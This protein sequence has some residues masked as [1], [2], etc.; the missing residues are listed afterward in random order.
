MPPLLGMHDGGEGV[1]PERRRAA[2]AAAPGIANF[3]SEDRARRLRG[4]LCL[5]RY[6]TVN[7]L[8]GVPADCSL[9]RYYVSPNIISRTLA[10]SALRR[11]YLA[12]RP[13]YKLSVY[14]VQ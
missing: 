11:I 2:A 3:A 14:Y 10:R 12:S 6:E 1:F 4:S 8:E 7:S 13:S 9:L 5:S